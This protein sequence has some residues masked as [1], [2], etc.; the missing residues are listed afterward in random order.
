MPSH[1]FHYWKKACQI[2]AG[3]SEALLFLGWGAWGLGYV[4]PHSTFRLP[5]SIA[6]S[7]NTYVVLLLRHGMDRT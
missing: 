6:V 5:N 7:V 2:W 4:P 3:L 1:D